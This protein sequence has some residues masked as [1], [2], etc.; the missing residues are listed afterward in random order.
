[1]VMSLIRG[2]SE[3]CFPWNYNMVME[4]I[5]VFSISLSVGIPPLAL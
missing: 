2:G 4:S 3:L 5:W 1:M